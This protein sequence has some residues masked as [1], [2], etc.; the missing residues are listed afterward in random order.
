MRFVS[1][2]TVH[3]SS[4]P[5]VCCCVWKGRVEIRIWEGL[6]SEQPGAEAPLAAGV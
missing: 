1:V 6:V 4:S 3:P 2:F 5:V